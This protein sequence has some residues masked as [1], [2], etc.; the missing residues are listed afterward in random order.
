MIKGQRKLFKK[1]SF[2]F[3]DGTNNEKGTGL[4]LLICK[5]YVKLHYGDIWVKS[6]IGKGA[7]FIFTLKLNQE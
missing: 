5:D 2:Y 6:R 4:G 3:T 7:E 1:E